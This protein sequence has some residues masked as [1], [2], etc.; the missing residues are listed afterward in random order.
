MTSPRSTAAEQAIK[1]DKDVMT[2]A[3]GVGMQGMK[4]RLAGINQGL[5]LGGEPGYVGDAYNLQRGAL[6][7]AMNMAGTQRQGMADAAASGLNQGGN[8]SNVLNPQQIGAQLADQLYS[9]RTSQA[10]GKVDETNNLMNMALGLGG[11][12]GS[13][14]MGA[15]QNQLGAISMMPNYNPAY[16]TALGFANLGG[17]I[18]GG[19][20]QQPPSQIQP[21]PQGWTTSSFSTGMPGR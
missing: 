10:L 18:Y 12:A 7:E 5:A 11:Q 21:L 2:Q 6:T 20:Q 19:F 15:A 3:Y 17:S 9:S 14:Q 4:Q 1:T 16:A 13:A 8:Y